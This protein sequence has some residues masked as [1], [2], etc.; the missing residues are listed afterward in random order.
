[1]H[2]VAFVLETAEGEQLVFGLTGFVG[3]EHDLAHDLIDEE[4]RRVLVIGIGRRDG[5]CQQSVFFVVD[6]GRHVVEQSVHIG[7]HASDLRLARRPLVG[8][9]VV[10]TEHVDLR[11]LLQIL[12]ARHNRIA[13]DVANEQKHLF[14]FDGVDEGDA[15]VDVHERLD[16]V[17]VAAQPLEKR[18]ARGRGRVQMNDDE[19]FDVADLP[20]TEG[21]RSTLDVVV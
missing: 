2:G 3:I 7:V 12:N 4:L 15:I 18:L 11:Q 17:D 10:L 9:I 14:V 16:A 8:L 6:V 21:L 13:H 20:W 5:E 1:L 19:V